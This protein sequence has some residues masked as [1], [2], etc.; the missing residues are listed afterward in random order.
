MANL[1]VSTGVSSSSLGENPVALV[2]MIFPFAGTTAP[3]GWLLCNGSTF[4]S[5]T[6]PELATLLGSTTLPDLRE[7]YLLGYDSAA[8]GRT[9]GSNVSASHSHTI[10]YPANNPVN[11]TAFVTSS[12]TDTHS[13]GIAYNGIAGDA[14]GNH[15]HN[16][17]I[18]SY[19]TGM[20]NAGNYSQAAPTNAPVSTGNH[21]HNFGYGFAYSTA[22]GHGHGINAV[23][24]ASQA[25]THSHNYTTSNSGT[26]ASATTFL[27]PTLYVNFI[28]KAG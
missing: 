26:I 10:T 13:H 8:S 14:N 7:K 24:S 3:D 17:G 15:G 22:G 23:N 28:I 19:T 6:Y 11:S 5:T 27:P 9:V 4:S 18:N 21:G 16:A 12:S 1:K 2:G 20:T 25:P